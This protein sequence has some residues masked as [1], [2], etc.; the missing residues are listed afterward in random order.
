MIWIWISLTL[1][2]LLLLLTAGWVSIGP[3]SGKATSMAVCYTLL[4]IALFFLL[5]NFVHSK[6]DHALPQGSQNTFARLFFVVF[7]QGLVVFRT[8]IFYILG[9]ILFLILL[10]L[11]IKNKTIKKAATQ[12]LIMVIVLIIA[13]FIYFSLK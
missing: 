11:I 6:I 1:F 9:Q 8:L 10:R 12:A 5:V 4:S 13:S 3:K 2:I 7:V